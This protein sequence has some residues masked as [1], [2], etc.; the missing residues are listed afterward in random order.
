MRHLFDI[1][2]INFYAPI[3]K[4]GDNIKN[5][6]DE[7]NSICDIMP[8]FFKIILGDFNI[9]IEKKVMLILPV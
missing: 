1:V 3:V 2:I 4:K 9:K 6:Y 5:T 8:N 7:L